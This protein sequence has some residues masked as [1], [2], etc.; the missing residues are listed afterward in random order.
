[1][2][3]GASVDSPKG[4]GE[5]E[6]F[7]FKVLKADLE[8]YKVY[9]AECIAE[10]REA[11]CEEESAYLASLPAVFQSAV[12]EHN[13]E[14]Q[15]CACP[16]VLLYKWDQTDDQGR[17]EYLERFISEVEV[18]EAK[19]K[20]S[21][22]ANAAASDYSQSFSGSAADTKAEKE[23]AAL[24]R[25]DDDEEE[26]VNAWLKPPLAATPREEAL[27]RGMGRWH[28][29]LAASDCFMYLLEP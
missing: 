11:F 26:E 23:A 2:G 6:F 9:R 7:A 12:H 18:E 14:I 10:D 15:L 22:A 25:G 16:A 1:M 3:A 24:M 8:R 13:A 17:K 29:Y 28:K 20:K 19:K 21:A 27:L 4:S 5:A